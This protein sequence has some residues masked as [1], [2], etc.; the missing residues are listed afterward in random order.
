MG[1]LHRL[2]TAIGQVFLKFFGIPLRS[3]GMG[4][5]HGFEKQAHEFA[6]QISYGGL[7]WP[8]SESVGRRELQLVSM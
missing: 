2:E 8:G 5:L 3:K 1:L 7:E 6:I 4:L